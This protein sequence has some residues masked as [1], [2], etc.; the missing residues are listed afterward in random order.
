MEIDN[1]T[2][3]EI[4]NALLTDMLNGI[5]VAWRNPSKPPYHEAIGHTKLGRSDVFDARL[6]LKRFAPVIMELF[7]ETAESN[8]VIESPLLEIRKMKK[9]LNSKYNA[10][11]DGRLF[12]KMDNELA[13]AGSIKARGGIYEVLCYA[14][15][16]A[17]ENAILEDEEDDYRVLLSDDAKETFGQYT[18]M[19]GSTG[20]LGISIG[21]MASALGFKAV[22][23]MSRDAKEWKKELLRSKGVTVIEHS[24]NYTEAVAKGRDEAAKDDKCHFVDDENSKELLLGYSICARNLKRQLA[25]EGVEVDDE[26]PL[27]VYIPC[28]VGGAPAGI[29]FGLKLQFGDNVHCFFVEP[30][31]APCMLLGLVTGLYEHISVEDMGISG[32]T[33]ADGLAVGRA[34]GF[35]SRLIKPFLSG[36]FTVH[37]RMLRRYLRDLWQS[38]GIFLEPSACAAFEGVAKLKNSEAGKDYLNKISTNR[39]K[40]VQGS[41]VIW[42]TG[43]GLVPDDVRQELLKEEQYDEE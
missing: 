43:G 42:A 17:F 6:R 16:V 14:E 20:N 21:T 40:L 8:G 10:Q 35:A 27:Y 23:H 22:V 11:L 34:S 36:A 2:A 3:L 38:E 24:G 39:D 5:D 37:D 30:V 28:G 1:M 19:V 9:Q 15:K 7:P 4:R 33:E 31:N 32:V 25:R 41:H 12:M 29:T 18:I 13:V 26:H